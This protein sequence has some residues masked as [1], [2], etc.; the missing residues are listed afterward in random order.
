MFTVWAHTQWN[1]PN[2]SARSQKPYEVLHN[3]LLGSFI[4]YLEKI[5]S[6]NY[7]ISN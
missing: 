5:V 7:L 4:D 6:L 3:L 1:I 2:F